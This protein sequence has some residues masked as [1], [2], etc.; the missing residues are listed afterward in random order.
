MKNDELITLR[1]G[2]GSECCECHIVGDGVRYI[3]STPNS[4]NS[5]CY[6]QWGGWGVW[7]CII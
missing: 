4:C 1:G 5:D 7:Q 2:Y 6:T 3:Q